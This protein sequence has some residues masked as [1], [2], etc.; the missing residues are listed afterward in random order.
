MESAFESHISNVLAGFTN[1]RKRLSSATAQNI[2][3]DFSEGQCL[4]LK[5]NNKTLL[6][7]VRGL[8]CLKNKVSIKRIIHCLHREQ[9][10]Y[11]GRD[12]R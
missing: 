12:D 1:E 9:C 11:S 4:C 7:L 2:L 3:L 5:K 8:R 6:S 10:E